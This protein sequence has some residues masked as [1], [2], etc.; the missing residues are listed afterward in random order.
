MKNRLRKSL[1]LFETSVNKLFP[2]KPI[3]LF[4]NKFDLFRAR[5]LSSVQ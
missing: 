1:E 3:V 4:L 2:D 5:V